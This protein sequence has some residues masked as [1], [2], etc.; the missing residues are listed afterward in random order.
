MLHFTLRADFQ[1]DDV[2]GE[3]HRDAAEVNGGADDEDFRRELA[4][5]GRSGEGKADVA[6]GKD[7]NRK[8]GSGEQF[9]R[10]N[11]DEL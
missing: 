11:L 2:I 10:G 7:G 9:P 5:K 3:Q 4:G 1:N 6:D 8:N